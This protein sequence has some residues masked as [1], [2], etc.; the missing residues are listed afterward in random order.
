MINMNRNVEQN[1][2]LRPLLP[3]LL[4]LGCMMLVSPT[5][6]QAASFDCVKAQTKVEKLIC[7]DAEL[8]KLDEE[9]AM[10]YKAAL[11]DQSQAEMTRQEQKLWLK[12]RNACTDIACLKSYYRTRIHILPES[13]EQASSKSTFSNA[14]NSGIPA[15]EKKYPPYPDVW[16][17]EYEAIPSEL[18][19][20]L[21]MLSNGDVLAGKKLLFGGQSVVRGELLITKMK[22]VLLLSDGS[23]VSGTKS[24]D[25]F[26]GDIK[27]SNG[28][29]VI[30]VG[31]ATHGYCDH[32]PIDYFFY[33]HDEKKGRYGPNKVIFILLDE[34][35]QRMWDRPRPLPGSDEEVD[36][37]TEE[38]PPGFSTRVESVWGG[39]ML[40][41]DDGTFL[42]P[43][44][45]GLIVRFDEHFNTQSPLLNR[46]FFVF[47]LN[48][49]NLF[50]DKINGKKYDLE[51]TGYQPVYDD[52]Y[53]YLTNIRSKQP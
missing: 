13:Q 51:K 2:G 17:W 41:L 44:S 4:L 5:P 49:S 30:G 20:D 32:G 28:L 25:L 19:P 45:N 40:P 39:H 22:N 43:M 7:V 24:S 46:R 36:P 52:L 38:G 11:Q 48:D 1:I 47:D 29:E 33:T 16:H 18:P 9:M 37:C 31:Y 12:H 26:G 14:E 15:T 3:P 8:S 21:F 34:P 42:L 27:F 35:K 23:Q 53:Q 10:G 50:I 6:T